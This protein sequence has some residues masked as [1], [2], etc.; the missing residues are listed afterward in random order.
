VL[1]SL[2]HHAPSRRRA[3]IGFPSLTILTKILHF[4][5]NDESG[6]KAGSQPVTLTKKLIAAKGGD[7]TT[8]SLKGCQ[9]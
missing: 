2:W 9:T 5:Q 8:L 6:G 4:V 3:F 7:T 1:L